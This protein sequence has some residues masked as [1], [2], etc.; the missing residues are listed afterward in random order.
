MTSSTGRSDRAFTF[1]EILIVISVITFVSFLS[2]P[3]LSRQFSEL[4][5][6][7]SVRKSVALCLAFKN[8]AVAEGRIISLEVLPDAFRAAAVS[9]GKDARVFRF[10]DP[11]RLACDENILFFPDGTISK[12]ELTL[13]NGR[14][15]RTVWSGGLDGTVRSKE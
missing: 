11:I 9:G 3:S 6:S 13:S 5:L 8:R 14:R 15:S 12:F 1:I 7:S 2:F 4:S 10:P